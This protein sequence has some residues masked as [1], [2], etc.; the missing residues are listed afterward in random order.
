MP[1]LYP[2][3]NE[4]RRKKPTRNVE[5]F[6]GRKNTGNFIKVKICVNLTPTQNL[7]SHSRDK[8]SLLL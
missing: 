7:L 8:T 6:R 2:N 1:K 5:H 4:V 3:Q